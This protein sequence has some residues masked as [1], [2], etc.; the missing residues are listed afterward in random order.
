MPTAA[1]CGCD[2]SAASYRRCVEC[3]AGFLNMSMRADLS[4]APVNPGRSYRYYQGRSV[5][6]PFGWGLSYTSFNL[7]WHR[8]APGLLRHRGSVA[9]HEVA[10]ANVGD[11][12][13][14][15]VVFAFSTPPPGPTAP[16]R[17]LVGFRRVSLPAGGST[18]VRFDISPRLLSTVDDAGTRA[19]RPGV[20]RVAFADGAGAELR[21][22][23]RVGAAAGH[24][25]SVL[26]DGAAG[27]Q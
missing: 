24:V 10:V 3:S 20:H 23:L 17:Q 1:D 8:P 13:G 5:L 6:Y 4:P 11:R 19:V 2:G 9:A 22:A 27:R 7:S 14:D 16:L 18:I 12:A 26:P 15:A 25:V 21:A